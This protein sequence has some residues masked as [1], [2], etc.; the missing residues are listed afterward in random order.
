MGI[1]ESRVRDCKGERQRKHT[2]GVVGG[3]S[4]SPEKPGPN[5]GSDPTGAKRLRSV[6]SESPSSYAAKA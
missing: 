4:R 1:Q 2:V 6:L 3:E 5:I